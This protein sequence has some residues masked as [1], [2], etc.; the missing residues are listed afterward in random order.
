MALSV[1]LDENIR[2][3]EENLPV[4]ESFDLMT[5]HLY[6]GETKAFFPSMYRAMSSTLS[7]FI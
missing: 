5:R 3:I 4:R 7:S 1:D 2:Y 6:L